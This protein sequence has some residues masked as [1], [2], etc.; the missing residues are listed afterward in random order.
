M[1]SGIYGKYA[2]PG[3]SGFSK[4]FLI[5]LGSQRSGRGLESFLEPM[6]FILT[7]YGPVAS[8]MDPNRLDI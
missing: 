2:F 1:D 3:I 4:V 8:L 5:F 6:R 7:E